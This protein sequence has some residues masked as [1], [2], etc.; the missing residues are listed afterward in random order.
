MGS[1]YVVTG[2]SGSVHRTPAQ[3]Q[4]TLSC[5]PHIVGGAGGGVGSSSVINTRLQGEKIL[6]DF[7]IQGLM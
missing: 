7:F 5:P 4:G 2:R 1:P 6:E 3:R